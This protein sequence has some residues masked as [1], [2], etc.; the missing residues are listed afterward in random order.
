[1]I[2]LAPYVLAVAGVWLLLLAAIIT[3]HGIFHFF[4]SK[5]APVL[6]GGACLWMSAIMIVAGGNA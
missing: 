4:A 2:S 3:A 6:I 5:V 1:M